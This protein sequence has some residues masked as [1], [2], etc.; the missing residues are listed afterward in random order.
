MVTAAS[1]PKA[2]TANSPH[3]ERNRRGS[4]QS[5][6]ARFCN[7]LYSVWADGVGQNCRNRH[8]YPQS[9]VMQK[10]SAGSCPDAANRTESYHNGRYGTVSA[11]GLLWLSSRPPLPT[12]DNCACG[13]AILPW[14]P[15][16]S[17]NE[18]GCESRPA[19]YEYWVALATRMF[20]RRSGVRGAG[21]VCDRRR[22]LGHLRR[23]WWRCGPAR[24]RPICLRRCCQLRHDH[25]RQFPAHG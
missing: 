11:L 7:K 22:R 24:L 3:A 16:A 17:N 21:F 18:G 20:V 13:P 14:M 2:V 8:Q 1:T 5:R 15:F 10:S 9:P 19:C 23:W 12:T 25:V 4:S 6:S